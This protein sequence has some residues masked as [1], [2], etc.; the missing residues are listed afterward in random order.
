MSEERDRALLEQFNADSPV[1]VLEYPLRGL[2]AKDNGLGHHIMFDVLEIEGLCFETV[3]QS[4]TSAEQSSVTE[5]E[6]SQVLDGLSSEDAQQTANETGLAGIA[7]NITQGGSLR[8][9]SSWLSNFGQNFSGLAAESSRLKQEGRNLKGSI[10]LYVPEAVNVAYGLDWQMSDD[11]VGVALI[12]DVF[13]L[14]QSSGS[15]TEKIAK[16]IGEQI[17]IQA[18]PNVIDSV[19][20]LVGVNFGG[21]AAVESLTRKVRNPHI[22]FLFK[23]VNQRTF[24]FEFNF[25]PQ[26]F[27]E[28]KVTYNIIKMFKK[29]SMPELDDSKRFLRYPS[30][31][32]I[33]YF[34]SAG[35][36]N[37]FVN[38]LKPSVITGINV[39]YSGGGVY[40]TFDEQ[41]SG[42]VDMDGKTVNGAPPTNVKL[43][44][45]F[46]ETSLLTRGDIDEGY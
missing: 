41:P 40:S 21:Q 18:A 13:K 22:A 35:V 10:A 32:E 42:F 37:T 36:E 7:N 45:T 38:K 28:A 11:M 19:G 12:E 25:T 20:S 24:S 16:S 6:N 9:L 23:G 39:D 27:E 43:T 31:F 29:H 46:S 34:S 33:S 44:L 26:N 5:N 3:S 1:N 14:I 15:G 8:N 2:G 17:A 4:F 30:L